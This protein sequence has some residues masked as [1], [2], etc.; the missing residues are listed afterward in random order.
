MAK[1]PDT[2]N[3]MRPRLSRQWFFYPLFAVL[4]LALLGL[5]NPLLV[6]PDSY[7]N[8]LFTSLPLIAASLLLILLALH[9]QRSYLWHHLHSQRKSKTKFVLSYMC[10]LLLLAPPGLALGVPSLLHLFGAEPA[11]ELVTITNRGAGYDS[12]GCDGAL[13]IAEYHHFLNDRVCGIPHDLW[14]AAAPGDTLLLD[15]ERSLLGFKARRVT[16]KRAK[17]VEEASGL[18][19]FAE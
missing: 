10:L 5:L 16:L 17:A 14:D 2:P 18:P 11:Q 13:Y 7:V 12:R 15:G 8:L 3:T 6:K 9:D 4:S 1:K 19:H